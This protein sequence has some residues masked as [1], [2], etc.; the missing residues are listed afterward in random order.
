MSD[1]DSVLDLI[2]QITG[3]LRGSY[4]AWEYGNVLLPMTLL[5]RLDS[6][7]TSKDP[8]AGRAIHNA[9]GLDF[10]RLMTEPRI[11]DK[12]LMAYV[13]GFPNDVQQIFASFDFQREI[14]RLHQINILYLT[15]SRFADIDLDP[16]VVP[17]HQM[18]TIFGDLISRCSELSREIDGDHFTP[19]DVIRLMVNLLFTAD[20]QLSGKSDTARRLLDPACG[21]GGTLTEAQRYLHER[22][23]ATQ[24]H[25]YGQDISPW[26]FARASAVTLIQEIDRPVLADKV[27]LGD[28]FTADGFPDEVFDYFLCNPPFGMEWKRQYAVVRQEYESKSGGRFKAGLPRVSDSSLLFLQHMW[29]KRAEPTASGGGSRLVVTFASSPMLTGGAGSGESEIRKWIIEND[30]LE[31]I[32]ALPDSIFYNTSLSAYLWLLTNRKE[33]RR[34]GKVQLIDARGIS[35]PGIG[36]DGRHNL[37]AKRRHLGE[38]EI[39]KIG[40]IYRTFEPGKQSKIVGNDD[41][42]Y[43]RMTIERPLRLRFEMTATRKERFLDAYPEL[44]DDVQAIERALGRGPLLDWT[45][46]KRRI[47]DV[48]AARGSRWRAQEF[49]TF[50]SVFT[51]PDRA[52]SPVR[53]EGQEMEFEPD[54]GLRE[55]ENVPLGADVAE[56][57]AREFARY[58]L[59]A[60]LADSDLKVGYEI[61]F[62]RY[63]YEFTPPRPLAD[64]DRDLER[65]EEEFRRLWE[66]R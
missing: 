5:R 31:A 9:S 15:I 19:R 13:E 10:R 37:G 34:R 59:T 61:G 66:A 58:D 48:L 22:Q 45:E 2:W 54:P 41:L 8:H 36:E 1:A 29:S 44:L 39:S 18:G 50:R 23:V 52:G 21:T 20:D 62:N 43:V 11:I 65:A 28:A 60:W 64:I 40:R 46:T 7:L 26:A 33:A 57:F 38:R 35:T 30:W 6:V 16:A 47:E 24:L 14:R 27:L 32:V 17:S 3:S 55:Y 4:M 56:Y 25:V 49:R 51:R 12:N 63:F 53:R 42:G